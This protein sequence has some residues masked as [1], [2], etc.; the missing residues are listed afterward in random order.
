MPL[1]TGMVTGV[2][3][4]GAVTSAASLRKLITTGTGT[5]NTDNVAAKIEV[6]ATVS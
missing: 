1:V 5:P 6:E 3:K 2:P 4:P